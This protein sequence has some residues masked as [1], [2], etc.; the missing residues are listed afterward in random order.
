MWALKVVL[1]VFIKQSFLYEGTLR[2]ILKAYIATIPVHMF[3]LQSN[4]LMWSPLLRDRLSY[5]VTFSGSLKPKYSANEP[6]LRGH[7]S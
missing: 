6:V 2:A 3:S 7:L 5:V 4:L 1:N